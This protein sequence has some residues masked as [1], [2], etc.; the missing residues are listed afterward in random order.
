MQKSDSKV[1]VLIIDDDKVCRSLFRTCAEKCGYIVFESSSGAEGV[2]ILANFQPDVVILDLGLPDFDGISIISRIR[3]WS[4][5]PI[6]VL[7]AR[8]NLQ[9][10]IDAF[11]KGA[12]D[13]VTKPFS[14][15]E[16][17]ART[18][19]ALRKSVE[20]D[21]LEFNMNGLN[22]TFASRRVSYKG[23]NLHFTPI[24]FSI[25]R[26]LVKN[27]GNVVLKEEM[28]R[29]I[30]GEITSSTDDQMRV[31]MASIRKKLKKKIGSDVLCTIRGTGY[32]MQF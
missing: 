20:N 26:A 25:L 19:V 23:E 29:G 13:Y 1:K 3:E 5:V 22:I 31:H 27:Y 9:D 17:L 15:Q 8:D 30:W 21:D 12:Q 4:K 6:I 32:K 18:R 28:S 14:A 24:E 16:L 2:S 10:K 11:D 7:S